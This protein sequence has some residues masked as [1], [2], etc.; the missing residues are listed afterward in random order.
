MSSPYPLLMQT[1][2]NLHNISKY[3]FICGSFFCQPTLEKSQ[4][5]S[6]YWKKDPYSSILCKTLENL[7]MSSFFQYWDI[8]GNTIKPIAITNANKI[9]FTFFKFMPFLSIHLKFFFMKLCKNR[10]KKIIS[11]LIHPLTQGSDH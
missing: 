2:Y 9:H 11:T 3:G 7:Y 1:S 10:K 4:T 8:H 5:I 6:K